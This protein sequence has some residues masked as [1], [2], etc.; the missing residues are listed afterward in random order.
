MKKKRDDVLVFIHGYEKGY[1][2]GKRNLKRKFSIS[3]KQSKFKRMI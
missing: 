2:D 1:N 3:R